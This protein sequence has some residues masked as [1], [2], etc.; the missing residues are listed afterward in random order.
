[1]LAI[2]YHDYPMGN[3]Q[4]L[5]SE[6]RDTLKQHRL[7]VLGFGGATLAATMVP[8]I[9]FIVIPAAVA[10]ATALYLERVKLPCEL[11]DDFIL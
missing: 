5:F 6:Q 11:M 4:I 8:L 9:N 3:H 7:L 2:D 10:G 1:M